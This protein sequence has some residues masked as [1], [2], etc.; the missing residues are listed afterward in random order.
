MMRRYGMFVVWE[1][2]PHYPLTDKTLYMVRVEG[3][4]EVYVAESEEERQEIINNLW[5]SIVAKLFRV[6]DKYDK[7]SCDEAKS[8]SI[9]ERYECRE[10]GM[11]RAFE[12][13]GIADKY[14]EREV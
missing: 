2:D 13:L 6:A 4:P 12:I 5:D 9:R 10:D 1:Q 7:W 11:Y 14:D 3:K 8:E